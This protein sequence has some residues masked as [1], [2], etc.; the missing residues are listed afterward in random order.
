[1]SD[2]KGCVL[3]FVPSCKSACCVLPLIWEMAL[4]DVVFSAEITVTGSCGSASP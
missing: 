2:R 3:W 1:M 4:Q